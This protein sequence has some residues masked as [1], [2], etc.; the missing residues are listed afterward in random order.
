ME[1]CGDF[2]K[3]GATFV[4]VPI[5]RIEIFWKSIF[6]ALFLE[7]TMSCIVCTCTTLT[8]SCNLNSWH[9]PQPK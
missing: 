9:K 1:P 5:I 3:F 7:A 4:G 2:P 6:G 8:V